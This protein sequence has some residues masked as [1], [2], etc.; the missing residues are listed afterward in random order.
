MR[1]CGRVRVVRASDVATAVSAARTDAH[2]KLA[3]GPFE[4]KV[5]VVGAE[6]NARDEDL[7]ALVRARDDDSAQHAPVDDLS[8]Q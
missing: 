1:A 5:P 4:G 8:H 2:G 7:D 3:A 6:R